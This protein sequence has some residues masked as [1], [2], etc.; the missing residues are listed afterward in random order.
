[1]NNPALPSSAKLLFH[2][3]FY[4]IFLLALSGCE[5]AAIKPAAETPATAAAPA[6]ATDSNTSAQVPTAAT[7]V[8]AAP[9]CELR[10]GFETW[11]PYQYLGIDQK[12]GGLDIELVQAIAKRMSCTLVTQHSNWLEL[13]GA[14]KEGKVDLLM[15]ASMTPSR[16]EFA[17]FSDPY[18]KEQ[19]VL[20][21]RSA[22]AA[23]LPQNT[24]ADFIGAGKKL[25]IVSE[26]YYGPELTELYS[27]ETYKTQFV[28]ASLSELNIARLVDEDIDGM[29]EDKF[30]GVSML[31][32]KGLDRDIGQHSITLGNTDV[33]V[34]FS[35]TTV[36]PETV[37]AFNKALAEIRQNGEYDAVLARYQY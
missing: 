18:R 15:G 33:Y 3:L 28:E 11:E 26:Y 1:M 17:H 25:G 10:L 19:F 16:Q 32:R 2:N 14:L 4:L 21:V 31:R 30:V 5:P 7:S 9:V 20:F 35:K 36:K 13:V 8:P 27:N 22:D 23:G 29:L 34:M 37:A 12:A 24:I 6:A